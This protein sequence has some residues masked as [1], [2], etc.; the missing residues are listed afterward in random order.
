MDKKFGKKR[1]CEN[2]ATRFYDLKKNPIICPICSQKYEINDFNFN[3]SS[4]SE[5]T[6]DKKTGL[7]TTYGEEVE[8]ISN[9]EIDTNSED[10]VISIEEVPEEEATN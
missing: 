5:I 8:E 10:D 2:C 9:Q 4:F 6:N 7:K 3:N 1:V